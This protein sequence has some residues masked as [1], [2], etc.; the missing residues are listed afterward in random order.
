MDIDF[1][2]V[3]MQIRENNI[4]NQNNNEDNYYQ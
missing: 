1:D 2:D 3:Q 4:R